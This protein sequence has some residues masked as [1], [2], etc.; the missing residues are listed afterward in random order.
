MTDLREFLAGTAKLGE[1]TTVRKADW[2]LE[3]GA[4]TEISG[5][6]PNP[7]ALLFE[8]IKDY[9]A[10]FRV[11]TNMFQTQS[12]TALALGLPTQLNGVELVRRG[13]AILTPA[14][15]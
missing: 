5:A 2:N 7:P 11:L 4:I 15:P 10:G 6:E 8:D 3:I 13:K 14:T 1:L 12:R 9:P